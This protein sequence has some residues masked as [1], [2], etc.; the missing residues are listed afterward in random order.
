MKQ[1]ISLLRGARGFTQLEA[2]LVLSVMGLLGAVAIPLVS[3]VTNSASLTVLK[4]NLHHMNAILREAHRAGSIGTNLEG[5]ESGVSVLCERLTH[6]AGVF[7]DADNDGEL[8][9][10]EIGF[11][12]DIPPNKDPYHYLIGQHLESGFA[13]KLEGDSPAQLAIYEGDKLYDIP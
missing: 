1:G 13:V 3:N 7:V 5:V 12:M 11:E 6:G 4:S 8:D 9:P 2:L 10:H